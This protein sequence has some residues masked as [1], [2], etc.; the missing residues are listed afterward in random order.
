MSSSS[1]A[2]NPAPPPRNFFVHLEAYLARRDGVDKLL[3]I[4]RYASRLA[5]A[6]GP[7]LP[8]AASARLKSF[9]SRRAQSQGLPPR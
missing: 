9:E 6:A 7:P 4:S 2:Q 1:D 3:E 5:L 8:P